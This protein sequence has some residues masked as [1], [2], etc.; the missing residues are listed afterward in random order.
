MN[1]SVKFAMCASVVEVRAAI[2]DVPHYLAR[3]VTRLPGA[4]L[5]LRTVKSASVM[6][7]TG[8]S[9]VSWKVR[10]AMVVMAIYGQCTT[11]IIGFFAGQGTA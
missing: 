11:D 4:G 8:L 5:R 9:R 3:Y 2:L 1:V 7:G 10:V 6:V